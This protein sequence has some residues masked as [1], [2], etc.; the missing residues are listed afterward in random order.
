MEVGPGQA[1]EVAVRVVLAGSPDVAEAHAHDRAHGGLFADGV[2]HI[3]GVAAEEVLA[4]GVGVGAVGVLR[5]EEGVQIDA[6]HGQLGLLGNAGR[7]GPHGYGGGEAVGVQGAKLF[8]QDFQ[9]RQLLHR[10][11]IAEYPSQEGLRIARCR[12]QAWQQRVV[13]AGVCRPNASP[14]ALQRR[15]GWG[16]G[17][18]SVIHTQ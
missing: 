10:G 2:E 14:R 5:P 6:D 8:A 13:V 11:F 4:G 9:A 15:P 3:G 7:L 17:A 18:C 1:D 12:D 16:G